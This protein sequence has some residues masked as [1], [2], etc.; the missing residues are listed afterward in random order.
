MVGAVVLAVY[1]A[2]GRHLSGGKTVN[3]GRNAT[4]RMPEK[5]A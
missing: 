2:M 5:V 4:S 1:P 3:P